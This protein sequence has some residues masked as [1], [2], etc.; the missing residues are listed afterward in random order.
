MH[1][2]VYS[3]VTSLIW[4]TVFSFLI[5]CLRKNNEFIKHLY[6]QSLVFL[7]VMTFLRLVFSFDSRHLRVVRSEEI[8]PA[9]IN[10]ATHSWF[11]LFNVP[12][13]AITILI[14]VWAIGIVINSVNLLRRTLEA[15]QLHAGLSSQASPYISQ[16]IE[17]M[18]DFPKHIKVIQHQA[19]T[20]PMLVGIFKP[21]LF[22]P[23]LELDDEE[24]RLIIAH[25]L[26]HLS[27]NDIFIKY[28]IYFFRILFWW[29]IA[30]RTL[31]NDLDHIL[32]MRCDDIVLKHA[33]PATE[34]KYVTV[35]QKVAAAC[36]GAS[37]PPNGAGFLSSNSKK[38]LFERCR[39]IYDR[40][41]IK[42]TPAISVGLLAVGLSLFILSYS[43]IIQP[44]YSPEIGDG[45]FQFVPGEPTFITLP[46]GTFEVYIGGVFIATVDNIS[47]VQSGT[48]NI[49]EKDDIP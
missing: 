45:E 23:E 6:L 2:T 18:P 33:L 17:A 36:Y 44:A 19:V 41:K 25:E 14:S 7:V 39:L 9:V 48:P 49:R 20:A 5:S 32:E 29:N 8:L 1:I 15:S 40:S 3:F 30:I 10:A 26:A 42:R 43:I 24:W 11:Q 21:V 13:S 4:F 34:K 12:V 38:M 28:S 35:L 46:D 22:L 27:R 47:N 31:V 37:T 16:V